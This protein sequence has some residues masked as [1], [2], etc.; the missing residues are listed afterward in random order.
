[1]WSSP[2]RSEDALKFLDCRFAD[3]TVRE[4]AIRYLEEMQDGQLLQ[5]LLQLVQCL[6]YEPDHNSALARFLIQRG[7]K[8]PYQ[9]GDFLFWHLKPECHDLHYCEKFGVIMEEY[10]LHAGECSR[11]LYTM[12]GIKTIRINCKK[13]I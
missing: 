6:K 13:N 11:Q 2:K 3:T 7:L 8:D 9:I 10:L 5:Y 4:K 12:Y 1:M